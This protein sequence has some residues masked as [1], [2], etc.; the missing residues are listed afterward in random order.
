MPSSSS[1]LPKT[2]STQQR[3]EDML[4]KVLEEVDGTAGLS[5]Q[6]ACIRLNSIAA[7]VLSLEALRLSTSEE[8]LEYDVRSIELI[9]QELERLHMSYKDILSQEVRNMITV[10]VTSR[11]SDA[12]YDCFMQGSLTNCKLYNVFI[13]LSLSLTC[14]CN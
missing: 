14:G 5:V 13:Y 6:D 3:L 7:A 1:R 10:F 8:K 2:P 4:E 12:L 9:N 11:F